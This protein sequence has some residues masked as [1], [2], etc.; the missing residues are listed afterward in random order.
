[1]R[2]GTLALAAALVLA[3]VSAC[4]C[5]GG[6]GGGRPADQDVVEVEYELFETTKAFEP[7]ELERLASVSPDGAVFEFAAPAPDRAASLRS[8]DVIVGGVSAATPKGFLRVVHHTEPLPGGG[9]R[10]ITQPTSLAYAFRSLHLRV[11]QTVEVAPEAH[12]S[13]EGPLRQAIE[14]GAPVSFDTLVFDGDDDP[15]TEDDQIRVTG[16]VDPTVWF[17]FDVDLDWPD[18]I[19]DVIVPIDDPLDLLDPTSVLPEAVV[20]LDTSARVDANLGMNGVAGLSYEKVLDFGHFPLG[21]YPAVPPFLV[22]VVSLDIEGRITGGSSSRFT[23][24]TH[25]STGEFGVHL[26]ASNDD[27]EPSAFDVTWPSP[28]FAVDTPVIDARASAELR[29]GPKV[30]MLLWDLAGPRVGLDAYARLEADNL[31]QPCWTLDTGLEG[32]VGVHIT[33][34]YDRSWDVPVTE[35]RLAE[36]D[37][38]LPPE[39][40][41]EELPTFT[42]WATAFA[43]TGYP[44]GEWTELVPVTDGR[45]LIAADMGRALVKATAAGEGIWARTYDRFEP[46]SELR[47]PLYAQRA[48][49]TLDAELLLLAHPPTLLRLDQA[50]GVR[51]ARKAS[52]VFDGSTSLHGGV[53]ELADGTLL[54]VSAYQPDDGADQDA[55]L[56]RVSRDGQLLSASTWGEDDRN[57]FPTA[58]VPWG[59]RLLVVGRSL[60][61]GTAAGHGWAL[62]LEPGRGVI[63]PLVIA[64]P[65]DDRDVALLAARGL[66]DGGVLLAGWVAKP[67]GRR[68]L[69]IELRADGTLAW[70]R[71]HDPA[72]GE[73]GFGLAITSIL[74]SPLGY[75]VAA[76]TRY[77]TTDDV[78]LAALDTAGHADWSRVIDGAE[79]PV[80]G[81]ALVA[82]ERHGVLLAAQ[83]GV[84]ADAGLLLLEAW[85]KDGRVS[86]RPGSGVAQ[87]DL[88]VTDADPGLSLAWPAPAIEEVSVAWEEVAVE[89]GAPDAFAVHGLA[90]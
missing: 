27:D 16:L 25:G 52:L 57:E 73:D 46:G 55:V 9:L 37:C 3:C 15:S 51:W 67:G 29:A 7:E 58:I 39:S 13:G 86:F 56:L 75:F 22:F 65:A 8:R 79:G 34:I 83:Q 78:W 90:P 50:G 28:S 30:A 76:G 87:S 26:V 18:D 31:R 64:D 6:G 45:F 68:G 32:N 70:Q 43:D 38:R 2:P 14:V 35:T 48:A 47:V 1:M 84:T 81:P 85:R 33:G 41:T 54:A 21:A 74:Q 63:R 17:D 42:P 49:P 53:V 77:D 82:T 88:A 11:R 23:V 12:G 80:A 10:V 5:D 19:W 44:S 60:S 4:S 59:D 61:P 24:G 71:A 69:V 66:S 40:G 20:R 62:V 72:P 89:V 36:G